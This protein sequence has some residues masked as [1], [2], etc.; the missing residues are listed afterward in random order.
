MP[1][2][3]LTHLSH[4]F[5]HQALENELPEGVHVAYDGLVLEVDENA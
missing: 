4:E 2:A 1:T 5:D 3:Y